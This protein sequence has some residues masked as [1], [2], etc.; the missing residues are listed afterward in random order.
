MPF[1][2]KHVDNGFKVCKKDNT[3]KCFS[4]DAIPLENAIKQKKAIEINEG[5][6]VNKEKIKLSKKL[7]DISEND[8]R[9]DYN[10]LLKLKITHENSNTLIGNVVLD[11]FFFPYRL[12]TKSRRNTSFY[13][14]LKDKEILKKQYF[15][16]FN[17][18]HLNKPNYNYLK[19]MYSFFRLYYG[20]I[21]NFKPSQ[22]IYIYDKFKPTSV[23]DFSAGWGGRLLGAMTIPNLKYIGF[24]TNIDLKEP[25]EKMINFLDCKDRC[26]IIFKDSSK[27]DYSK[28]DYD[29]V[30][31]SPPY[32]TLEKYENMP[33][34]KD[35]EDWNNNFLIPVIS[36]TYKYLKEGG[37]YI[38]NIN[39][40]IYEDIVKIIGKCDLKIPF[41]LTA[42]H[43]DD[44][45]L[46]K[47]K[48]YGEYFYIWFKKNNDLRGGNMNDDI[49]L[50]IAKHRAMK[51]GYNPD[52]LTYVDADDKHKLDYN[53]TKF[54]LKGYGDFIIYSMLYNDGKITKEEVFKRRRSY[55]NRASNIKGDWKDNPESANNL[56][57]KI[58]W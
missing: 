21:S 43:L 58:Q 49:Y 47:K 54:G 23:L 20:S 56:S 19:M 22:A 8:A 24:D 18:Y 33:D 17:N 37:T 34:Y 38:I 48:D 52:L 55:L 27:I 13:E 42:R 53:G 51:A 39:S 32:Y 25:Y 12:D 45:G 35:Y 4:N 1:I 7:K 16:N 11:Y 41:K 3:N 57:L 31:T 28:Y 50:S 2:I 14:L 6:R 36:N 30:F 46:T 40:D 9:E 15:I 44:K 5:G 10:K 26:K 29:M